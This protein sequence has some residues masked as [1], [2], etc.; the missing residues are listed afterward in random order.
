MKKSLSGV[1]STMV[2]SV[3]LTHTVGQVT[4]EGYEDPLLNAASTL[5]TFQSSLPQ[6]DKFGW[7]YGVSTG[8]S[9]VFNVIQNEQN[10]Y[11]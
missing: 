2:D 7:F 5:R 10:C 6:M 4:F 11:S 3:A 9:N 1:M 8:W